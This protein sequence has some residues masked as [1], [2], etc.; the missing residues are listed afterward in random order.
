MQPKIVSPS[1]WVEARKQFLIKEKE[2]TRL[3]DELSRERR[4][5]PWERVDK[6]YVFEG[7]K[8]NESLSD[9]FAGR[10]QLI[11]YHFMFPTSWEEGCP[12]CS[13]W[14]DNFN[15]AIV[16][17]SHRDVTMVAISRAPL[18]GTGEGLLTKLA[19][20]RRGSGEG[21]VRNVTRRL[22]RIVHL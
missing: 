1:E 15:G 6:R 12:S 3:R 20:I 11:V 17:L 14:A 8:G 4:E 13:F 5:L 2:F 19:A 22:A 7:P 9:L 10:S 16:H 18:G 21:I